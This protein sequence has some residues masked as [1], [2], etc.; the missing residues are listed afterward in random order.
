[1]AWN[2]TSV[3]NVGMANWLDILPSEMKR[4]L[5][6]EEEEEEEVEVE[7]EEEEEKRSWKRVNQ[8]RTHILIVMSL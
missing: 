8:T 4:V 1:L 3:P 5:R 2:D 6:K 7:V